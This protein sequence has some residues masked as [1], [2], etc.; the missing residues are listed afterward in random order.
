MS[1]SP[2]HH[3]F[4]HIKIKMFEIQE[5]TRMIFAPTIAGN[6][7]KLETPDD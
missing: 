6:S 4:V 7:S 2:Q 1:E 3:M 5:K